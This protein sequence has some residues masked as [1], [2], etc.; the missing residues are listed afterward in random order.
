MQEKVLIE[1]EKKA[2]QIRRLQLVANTILA[3]ACYHTKE[4]EMQIMKA[5]KN[6]HITED[7]KKL[8]CNLWGKRNKLANEIIELGGKMDE[9]TT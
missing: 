7:E 3:N 5:E 6:G 9:T 1:M 8:I 4:M 2:K